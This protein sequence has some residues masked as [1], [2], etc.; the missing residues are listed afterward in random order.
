[1]PKSSNKQIKEDEKKVIKL[2]LKDSRQSPNEIAEKLGFSRQKAWK[3]IKRLEKNKTIWGYT[4]VINEGING[5][6][7]YFAFSKHK[8][9]IFVR[10]NEIVRDVQEDTEYKFNIGILGSYYINGTYDWIIIFSAKDIRDAKKF[11]DHVQSQYMD[12]LERIDLNECIFPLIKY[13][14]LNPNIEKLKEFAII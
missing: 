7:I 12:Q 4:S 5:R 11:C 1:M 13:G 6:N 2:L 9:P 8:T 14:K 10:I 3:I